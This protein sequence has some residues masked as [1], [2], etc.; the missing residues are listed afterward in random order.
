[1]ICSANP[2]PVVSKIVEFLQKFCILLVHDLRAS[3]NHKDTTILFYNLSRAKS[4]G[5]L[6]SRHSKL[7]KPL[8]LTK[9][10]NKNRAKF[11]RL[12][13]KSRS[14]LNRKICNQEFNFFQKMAFLHFLVFFR[15]NKT[16]KAPLNRT[17]LTQK[18]MHF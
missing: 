11:G 12:V 16:K 5:A 3:G 15:P 18:I 8:S 9:K 6:K 14:I 7:R 2:T 1:M 17:K 10:Y 13:Q 4:I